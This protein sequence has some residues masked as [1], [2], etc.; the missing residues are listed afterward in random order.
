MRLLPIAA[1]LLA[2]APGALA[3]LTVD[4]K[5]SDF[6]NL[7]GLYAENYGPYEEKVDYFSFDLF[8]IGPWLD[9]VK[10]SKTDIDFYDICVKYVASLR[11]SHDEFTIPSTFDAWLHFDG[12]IYDGKFLIDF[13]DRAYLPTKTFPFQI[14]DELVSVDGVAVADLLT[15]FAPYSVNGSANLV[16]QARIAAGTITERYQGWNPRAN[17][18]GVNATIVVKSQATGTPATYMVPWDVEGDAV[19]T[20]GIVPSPNAR[21]TS[22]PETGS[23]PRQLVVRRKGTERPED[24]SD[25][26][27]EY[28]SRGGG[29]V[30]RD[31]PAPAYMNTLNQIQT[32]GAAEGPKGFSE[33]SGLSPFGSNLPV[34]VGALPPNFSVRLGRLSTDQFLSGTFPSGSKKIGYIRIWTMSPT[35][36][37]LAMSQFATEVEFFDKNVDGLV[38]DVM[39]NGGGSLCYAQTLASMLIP[40]SFWGTNYD[41]RASLFWKQAFSSSIIS[42]KQ[43]GAPGWVIADYQFM[44]DAV[45][46]ALNEN[47]ALTG[48]LPICSYQQYSTPYFDSTG[49]VALYTK[50]LIVLVDNFTLSA[51]EGFTMFLQD[52]A[53]GPIVGTTTDGGG[54]NVNSWNAT[55]YSE[56]NTRITQSLIVRAKPFQVPGFPS[57]QYYDGVGIYPDIWLDY[58]TAS[59]LSNGGADFV[60]AAVAALNSLI[61]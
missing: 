48:A 49:T 56:G 60:F 4:Q 16:S 61:Q 1:G 43:G 39:E 10:A 20:A 34:F 19:T 5:V 14:G 26:Y 9:Q 11:D 23:S 55:A 29:V 12:D 6:M 58:M 53:R 30:P 15:Q 33:A 8:Q 45:N 17:N 57:L 41:I 47:R 18:I 37:T 3:D 40:G 22:K 42:A 25:P 50:P 31:P 35:N 28:F 24:G 52:N 2:L 36:T 38:V 21:H 54:G 7:A 51:A 13:I 44:L 32:M 46:S 59:N 27:G